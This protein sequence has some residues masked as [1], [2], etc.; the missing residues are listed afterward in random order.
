MKDWLKE[1]NERFGFLD[2]I[3]EK[4]AIPDSKYRED[5]A[6]CWGK[7]IREFIRLTLQSAVREQ[8]ERDI[9]LIQQVGR[10]ESICHCGDE[11]IDAI[12]A[13]LKEKANDTKEG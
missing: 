7:E 4:Y 12:R 13:Q 6:H 9:H 10:C 3:I 11:A 1:Y 5:T 8:V 2:N